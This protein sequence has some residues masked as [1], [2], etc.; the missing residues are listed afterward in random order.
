MVLRVVSWWSFIRFLH[1][2]SAAL[3][4][5]GQLAVS[6]VLLPI[7]RRLLEPDQR[8]RVLREVGRRFG[9]IT[10]AFF[11]PVQIATGIALARHNEVTWSSLAHTDYGRTLAAKLV[12][13]AVVMLA[14]GLHGL[15]SG[16]GHAVF[17]RGMAIGALVG[18]IGVILLATALPTG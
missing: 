11:L 8:A 1:V 4:V 6:L 14:A 12:L 5:G 9:V 18:S 13:F 17:A 2:L 16:R 7:A 3:W 10:V 15:A